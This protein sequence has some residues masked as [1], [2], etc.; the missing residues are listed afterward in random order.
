[1]KVGFIFI[2]GFL[3]SSNELLDWGRIGHRTVGEVA[4][5]HI[6]KKT[7]IAIEDLLEGASIAYISTYADEIKSDYRYEIG[8]A[9]V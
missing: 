5:Q 7:Q 2:L 6:S 4:A 9:H 8:R 1:M 3:V